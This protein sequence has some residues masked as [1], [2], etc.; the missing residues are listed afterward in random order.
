ME[1]TL[2]YISIQHELGMSI[3]LE[4]PLQPML[5]RFTKVAVRR[6]N[7]AEVRLYFLHDRQGQLALPNDIKSSV[8]KPYFSSTLSETVA[9]PAALSDTFE[10]LIG[11]PTDYILQ[12]DDTTG[13]Y[14]YYYNLTNIGMISLH[15]YHQ[16]IHAELL[17]LLKPIVERLAISCQASIEHHHLLQAIDDRKRA[18]EVVRFQLLHDELTQLPNR[19]SFMRHLDELNSTYN[20]RKLKAAVLFIDFDR[21]K[22]VNDTLGHAVG[23]SLL[24]AIAKTFIKLVR[25]HEMVARLSG[26][27]FVIVLSE[28]EQQNQSVYQIVENTLSNIQ[29]A[30]SNPLQAGEHLLHITPSIGVEFFPNKN[31]TSEQI[32]RH[33]DTAMYVAKSQAPNSAVIY[34]RSMSVELEHRQFIEKQLQQAIKEPEQFGLLYQPQFNARGDCIGAEAL[35]RWNGQNLSPEEFIPV[36]EDTGLMLEL[37][38]QILSRACHDLK[39]LQDESA[40]GHVKRISV[41]VSALQFNQRNFISEL[42]S[43]ISNAEANSHLI[44][45]EITE[46][47]LVKNTDEAIKKIAA[48]SEMGIRVS[49][50]DFGTGYSSL[51]YLNRLPVN[52]LKIDQTFVKG[53]AKDAN[54][55]AIVETIMALGHSI[56]LSVMAEGVENE[57][58][59]QCLKRL[60]CELYQG[61]YFGKP[62]PLAMAKHSLLPN[63]STADEPAN[64]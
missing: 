2:K 55:L 24:Q 26:D 39:Q 43:I 27:E 15:L 44:G 36:A 34:D 8:L 11:F 30:F 5:R 57:A 22:T 1:N 62:M 37:G 51:A 6:L 33:A 63:Y 29:L 12:H 3:G 58:D 64:P 53:I 13:E 61:F 21:F 28:T 60:G 14:T 17:E 19:R 10:R 50:D 59:L 54:N 35:V 47:A 32:L 20:A 31:Y 16:P 18:E 41:N 46:S 40:T 7:L 49:I 23:D 56:G 9:T 4:L 38:H 52:A 48:L 25:S 42:T 45:I